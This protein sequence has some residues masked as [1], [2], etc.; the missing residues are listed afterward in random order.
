MGRERKILMLQLIELT[1]LPYKEGNIQLVATRV[2]IMK[3]TL[4]PDML[5]WWIR[6]LYEHAYLC[7]T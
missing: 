1:L 2:N 4:S 7:K 5:I 3:H 6:A